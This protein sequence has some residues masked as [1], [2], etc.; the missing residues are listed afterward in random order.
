MLFFTL[1]AVYQYE[2]AAEV[3]IAAYWLGRKQEALERFEALLPRVP[4]DQRRWAEEQIAICVRE[5][6]R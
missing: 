4:P 3:A 2:A 5:L 6:A 1:P